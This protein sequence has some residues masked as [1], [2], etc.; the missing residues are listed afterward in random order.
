MN[1][2]AAK[3]QYY[4]ICAFLILSTFALY[5]P[6]HNY[7]FVHYDDTAY[8]AHNSNV[9][10][11]LRWQNIKWAFNIGC[12]SNW[13]PLT[14]VSHM[15]DCQLYGDSP[16]AHHLTNVIFHTAN[17]LL[18]FIVLR[19]MTKA[20]WASA[21]AAAL[22]AL[23]PLHIESVAWISERK[24]VLSTFFWMLTMLAYVHY[25]EKPK[26][27]R[28]VTALLLF[29]MGL[30]AKP[31]LVTLPFV[32]LLLDYWPLERFRISEES[33]QQKGSSNKRILQKKS[34]ALVIEKVPFFVFSLLSSIITII[35]QRAGGAVIPVDALSLKVRFGNAM[36]S[37]ITYIGKMFWPVRLAILYP[38]PEAAPPAATVIVYV[39]LLLSLS[40]GFLYLGRRYSF[41]IVGWLWYI[42]TLVPVIGIVQVG[43]QGMADRY[44]YIPLTGLF[45]I[46]AWTTR[47]FIRKYP[48]LKIFSALATIVIL[49]ALWLCSLVQLTH[50]RDS[51]TLFKHT[52]DVTENNYAIYGNF[53]NLLREAGQIDE[54][55][56]Y[57]NKSLQ[58]NPNNYTVYSSLGCALAEK[59]KIEEAINCF[60]KAIEL[61]KNRKLNANQGPGFAEAHYNLASLLSQQGQQE[62]AIEH[63]RIF[64][65]IRPDDAE[66]HFNFG[67]LL[68][69]QG[70][71]DFAIESFRRA[72]EID[73]G[74][75]KARIELNTAL[76]SQK[77]S[78]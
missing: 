8:V 29:V 28:Y 58:I 25:S 56:D 36:M 2:S 47:E 70:K 9:N 63:L 30:M 16:G 39:A 72:L 67:V 31:M 46:I 27:A 3:Y 13:H 69:K 10:T 71:T 68:Q 24:D 20:L 18:L 45:I 33:K 26:P 22:F 42:G 34:S 41:L 50:W 76:E 75:E 62:Q 23:H 7:K 77:S 37:Y 48:T 53:G 21:F 54:A 44:T 66:M 40:I 11:G 5:W 57:Y 52:I 55:I 49:V 74:Y 43:G 14:W 15:L 38:Y 1:E 17:T 60:Q 12:T 61:T 4:F 59:G 6:V 65:K 35:A 73:P 51:Y 19:R 32:L 64:L 78:H